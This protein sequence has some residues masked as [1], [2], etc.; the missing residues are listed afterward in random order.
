MVYLNIMPHTKNKYL[1]VYIDYLFI[2]IYQVAKDAYSL[3]FIFV[4]VLSSYVW[5]NLI[6]PL[7]VWLY[8]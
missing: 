1:W 8:Y 5:V 2:Y 7:R 6:I 3:I 4:A